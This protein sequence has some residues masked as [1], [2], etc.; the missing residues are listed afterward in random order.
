MS[1]YPSY[2]YVGAPANFNG[3]YPDGGDSGTLRKSFIEP[4]FHPIAI[5]GRRC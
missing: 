3:T 2:G 4:V 5:P 1:F